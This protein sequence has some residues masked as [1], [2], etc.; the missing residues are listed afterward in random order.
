MI[1]I[2]IGLPVLC[3]LSSTL[4]LAHPGSPFHDFWDGF[5]HPISGLDHSLT[6]FSVGILAAY[7]GRK[8]CLFFPMVFIVFMVFGGV[9]GFQGY[10]VPFYE[11][12]ISCSLLFLGLSLLSTLG[13]S[14][15]LVAIIL[16]IFG[17]FHGNAHGWELR[18]NLS[19][20]NVAVGFIAATAAL[21]WVGVEAIRCSHKWG[22]ITEAYWG[23]RLF[24][25]GT[26][27]YGV[28]AW[29]YP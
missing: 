24:G 17:L 5:S 28:W 23:R 20:T 15:P 2:K 9:I 29:V 3:F 27:L 26:A 6:A 25:I 18:E 16:S 1:R 14:F 10:A 7:Q 22:R 12:G 11:T 4:V 8:A 13:L 21:H 19:A